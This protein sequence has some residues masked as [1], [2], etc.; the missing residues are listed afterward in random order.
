MGLPKPTAT[1]GWAH[2]KGSSNASHW[3]D[4]DQK[5]GPK[6]A[7]VTTALMTLATLGEGRT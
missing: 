7:W 3:Y 6:V 4:N 1:A 2:W 5:Q